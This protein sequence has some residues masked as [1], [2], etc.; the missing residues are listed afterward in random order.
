MADEPNVGRP[1]SGSYGEGAEGERLAAGIGGNGG[2]PGPPP[3]PGPAPPP[4]VRPA[5][6]GAPDGRPGGTVNAVPGLPP[7]LARASDRPAEPVWT[8]PADP[9]YAVPNTTT[10][11]AQQQRIAVLDALRMSPNVSPETREWAQVVLA[12]LLDQPLPLG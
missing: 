5:S 1:E 6:T 2:G 3:Y 7:M 11:S 10:L 4:E 12:T 8:P 9:N